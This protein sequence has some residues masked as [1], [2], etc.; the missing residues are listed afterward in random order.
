MGT[1]IIDDYLKSLKAHILIDFKNSELFSHNLL[2]GENNECI[3]IERLRKYLPLKYNICSGKVFDSNNMLSDQIDIIISDNFHNSELI[4][5]PKAKIIPAEVVYGVISVKTNLTKQEIK[6]SKK[7]KG[8]CDNISSVKK[9]LKTPPLP[10]R[11]GGARTNFGYDPTLGIVFAYKSNL[12]IYQIAKYIEEENGRLGF[13]AQV[14]L[15]Y[16]FNKGLIINQKEDGKLLIIEIKENEEEKGFL[17][18]LITLIANF[19]SMPMATLNLGQYISLENRC[20]RAD[21]VF[22]SDVLQDNFPQ[23][24]GIEKK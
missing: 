5:L 12:S 11:V 3:L 22:K 6:G 14:D 8:V 17:N 19:N 20:I 1:R 10:L 18:F 2:K 7:K 23:N 21:S 9:L 4:N 16:V 13:I 24:I 15:V